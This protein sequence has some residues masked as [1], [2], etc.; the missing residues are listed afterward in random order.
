MQVTD[1][2]RN[3]V[4]MVILTGLLLVPAFYAMGTAIDLEYSWLKRAAYLLTV[5]TLLAIPALLLKARTY[6]LAEGILNFLFF[7]IDIASLHLNRQSTST[8]FLQNIFETNL[9]EATELLRS[10]WLPATGVIVLWVVYFAIAVRVDNRR[11]FSWRVTRIILYSAGGLLVTGIAAMVILLTRFHAE[12][13]IKSTLSEAAGLVWVK[14]YK[15]YPYNLYIETADLLQM[16]RNRRQLQQQVATFRFGIEP[17]Q[18]ENPELY[19]LVIG[20]AAR[21]DHFGINGYERNTTPLLAQQQLTSYEHV[22]T[23][24]NVT[25]QSLPMIVTRANATHIERAYSEKGITEAFQEAGFKTGWLTKQ[26]PY[27]FVDR[28]MRTCDY[29]RFYA[30]GFDVDNNYDGEMVTDLH[31]YIEDTLQFFVLHSLGC[32]FR[33]EQ[34]YPKSFEHFTPVLG[35]SFSY[36]MLK[37]ENKQMLVNAYD[38]AILYTDYFLSELIG[39]AD[40]L[41]RAAVVLYVADHGESFWDDERKLSLHS[42]YQ[43]SEYEYHVPMFVWCSEEYCNRYPEKIAAIRHNSRTPIT[44]AAVFHSL[45]DAAGISSAVDSTLSI[46]S[47]S[48]HAVDTIDVISGSGETVRWVPPIH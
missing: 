7:P 14:L 33:Y 38:N 9:S 11:L 24:A 18:R 44:T 17:V 27:P 15:I 35:Q 5:L 31:G 48:L 22:Y 20:E 45:L 41:N 40:S 34:R 42:S 37:E 23:Q 16:R 39:Y 12:R 32:H 2:I 8:V 28:I 1:N 36:S 4:R 47:Y 19:I 13:D 26:V 10:S 6:F 3:T 30:K 29:S 43:V 21:Y 46:C 25:A